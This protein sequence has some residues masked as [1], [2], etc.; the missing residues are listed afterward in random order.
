MKNK[1]YSLLGFAARSRKVVFGKERIRG[2]IRSNRKKKLVILATNTSERI[3]KDIKT[4][5]RSFDVKVIEMF[6]KAELGKL[7]GKEEISVFGIG[8]DGIID[9]IL[10]E[11][12]GK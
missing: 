12:E 8:D 1:I 7:I 5:C 3:K 11:L 2:Y 9:G 4:R 6:T 10:K